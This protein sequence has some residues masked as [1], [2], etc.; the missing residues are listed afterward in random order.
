MPGADSQ[1]P[2]ALGAF[3]MSAPAWDPAHSAVWYTDANKG[4]FVVALT[5]DVGRL[6]RKK[7]PT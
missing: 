6:L 5:N 7:Q 1:N 4:F 3:A 2:T